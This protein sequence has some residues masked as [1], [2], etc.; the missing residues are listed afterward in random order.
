MK[1]KLNS[2]NIMRSSL[3]RM[4]ALLVAGAA[5]FSCSSLKKMEKNVDKIDCTV[6]P[7]VLT[8]VGSE[9]PVEITAHFPAKYFNKKAEVTA[10]PV[11]KYEGGETLYEGVALQGEKVIGNATVIEKKEGGDVKY[12]GTIPFNE[13]MR[14]SGLYVRYNAEK[15]K[16]SREFDSDKIAD[17]VIATETLVN[18]AGAIA[19]GGN[20]FQRITPETAEAAIYYLI[21]S[22]QIRSS[23]AKSA[24]IKAMEK[25]AADA[26]AAEDMNLKSVEVKS[27][28]SPDGEQ[29]WNNTVA[30]NRDKASGKMIAKDMKKIA[31]AKNADFFKQYITAE[32]WE[33]FQQAMEESNI[34]DKELILRVLSMYSDPDVRER[35][36]KNITSAYTAVADQILPKL[37]RSKFIVNAERI[38]KSDE[39]IL[40]LVKS[41]PAELNVEEM[42]YATTLVDTDAEKMAIFAKAMNQFPQDWRAYNDYGMI[43]FQQGEYE[44]AKDMFAKAISLTADPAV[45]NNIGCIALVNGNVEAAAVAFGAADCEEADYNM[46]IVSILNGKYDNAVKYFGACTSY[47]A[48][49]ASILAGDNAVA[50]QKL[51]ASKDD[52]E[53]LKAVLAA[54]NNNAEAVFANLN[55]A[56]AKDAAYKQIAATDMEFAAYF[57]TEKFNEIVK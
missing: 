44:K 47:N 49:L 17:G 7:E 34:Q 18:K 2:N 46:G 35:E 14:I 20:A 9:V 54:R 31:E 37:R 41:N 32:D 6:V 43:L 22:A 33:G 27:Y 11:L 38:G 48:C 42:L 28:A 52:V 26:S 25:F 4:S 21:N 3:L 40:A 10:S 30:T 5:A 45:K 53:Y 23:Q 50:A 8:V 56:I 13:A 19:E 24:E 51:A 57:D 12:V 36:I 55:A 1:F 16:K 15:G 29:A 39:E